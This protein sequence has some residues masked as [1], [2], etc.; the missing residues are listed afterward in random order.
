MERPR[1]VES[2][3][4]DS[5]VAGSVDDGSDVERLSVNIDNSEG[6]ESRIR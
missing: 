1:R 4:M 6:P 2:E 3:R 5:G